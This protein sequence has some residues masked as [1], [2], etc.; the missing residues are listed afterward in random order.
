MIS[1]RKLT[2][3]DLEQ[4]IQIVESRPDVFMGLKDDQFKNNI[5]NVLPTFINDP[6]YFNIGMFTDGRLNG[7][8]I[9]KEMT[10]QPSWVWGYWLVEKSQEKNFFTTEY[11]KASIAMENDLFA[12]MEETRKLNRFY[13]SYPVNGSNP[14]GQLRNSFNTSNRLIDFAMRNQ[15]SRGYKFR[16]SNYKFFTDCIIPANTVPKYSYQKQILVE[17]VWPID[18]SIRM[19]VLQSNESGS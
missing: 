9:M 12:E 7:F 4:A 10:T 18:L 3:N 16:V 8:G 6:L 1:H 14:N 19:A 15:G 17:R 5:I 11:W 2:E 13:I